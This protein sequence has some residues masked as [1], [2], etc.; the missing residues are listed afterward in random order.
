MSY[1]YPT[2]LKPY[3]PSPLTSIPPPT[4]TPPS[5]CNSWSFQN[6]SS[7][8]PETPGLP[9]SSFSSFL[10][11]PHFQAVSISI[12]IPSLLYHL[13]NLY[14]YPLKSSVTWVNALVFVWCPLNWFFADPKRCFGAEMDNHSPNWLPFLQSKT[15]VTPAWLP[16]CELLRCDRANWVLE[17]EGWEWCLA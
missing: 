17:S 1:T 9:P 7:T 13:S 8:R 6:A 15:L 11:S 10:P 5:S 14:F 3:L 16:C 2:C 12:L 4:S